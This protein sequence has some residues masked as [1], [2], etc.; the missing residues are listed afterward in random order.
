MSTLQVLL[1]VVGALVALGIWRTRGAKEVAST[2]YFAH[3]NWL[4]LSFT[5]KGNGEG[6]I[7]HVRVNASRDPTGGVYITLLE[8][9]FE[10][11]GEVDLEKMTITY[12]NF[13]WDIRG[14]TIL[15]FRFPLYGLPREDSYGILTIGI[16][17]R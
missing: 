14:W 16:S 6:I 17:P 15:P 8:K 1:A 12:N 4:T 10:K 5:F 13:K 9:G 2:L 11:V 7:T 3:W